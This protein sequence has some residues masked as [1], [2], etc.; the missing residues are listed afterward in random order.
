MKKMMAVLGLLTA[1]LAPARAFAQ[2]P[3]P[4]NHP[5]DSPKATINVER[6][7]VVGTTTLKPGEYRFQ[8][9]T[10]DGRTFLVVTLANGGKE[11]AR[12]PCEREQLNGAISESEFRTVIREG[13]QVLVSV[14]IKG[15]SVAHTVVI[16]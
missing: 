1:L 4:H 6:D 5:Y 7:L 9:R 10:I 3:A 8:C 15:E 2:A 12:V 13:Q 14:R 11:I 16:N